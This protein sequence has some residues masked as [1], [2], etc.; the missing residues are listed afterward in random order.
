M[1]DEIYGTLT[2]FT[3]TLLLL[4]AANTVLFSEPPVPA[5]LNSIL[6]PVGASVGYSLGTMRPSED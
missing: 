6:A 2:V 1:K 3:T 4:V 5:L